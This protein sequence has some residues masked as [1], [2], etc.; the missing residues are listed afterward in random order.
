MDTIRSTPECKSSAVEESIFPHTFLYHA[1]KTRVSFPGRNANPDKGRV[2]EST[3]NLVYAFFSC[4]QVLYKLLVPAYAGHDK[5][6][7]VLVY[8]LLKRI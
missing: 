1:V 8:E 3:N 2:S 4:M 6:G 5:G 7:V